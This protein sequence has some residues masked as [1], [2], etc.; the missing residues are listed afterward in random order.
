[1]KRLNK[2]V[3]VLL[4]AAFVGVAGCAVTAGPQ[5]SGGQKLD[6]R[7]EKDK[8]TVTVAGRLF[9]CYKFG[10][11]QKYPYFWP[12]NGPASGKSITTETS[13][14]YPHHHSLFFGCDRVN[15]GNYWQE[16]NE[17]GQIVSQGP[18]IVEASGD[19]VVLAD[20][21]LW[22]QPGKEPVIRD[23]RLIGVT[24]PSPTVRLIDFEITLEPLTDIVIL[25]TNHSL[26]SARVVPELSV[27]S[28]GRLINAEGKTAEKGTFGV[29]SAWCDYSGERD[30]VAEG[31][32]I[33]QN[34]NNRWYPSKWFT[35]DYGFFSPTP[36]YWLEGGRLELAKGE[37][38]RLSYRVVVHAGDVE[39][40]AVGQLFEQYRVSAG[41]RRNK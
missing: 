11:L 27:K 20:E 18:K 4:A 10:A 8:V 5:G 39:A 2:H 40:A 17:R 6:A 19:K 32:A 13:E 3:T 30:G 41:G 28:G 36:M 33:L 9:T 14:P 37:K 23:T 29:A 35:R 26:F 31:I 22:Q 25:K 12:V 1:M 15:G 24:A 16:G 21:C 38:L 34:P 7:I